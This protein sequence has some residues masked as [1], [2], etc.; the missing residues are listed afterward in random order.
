MAYL[1]KKK[2]KGKDYYYLMESKRIDGKPRHTKQIYLGSAEDVLNR[3]I[4]SSDIQ[5]PL[6]S[7]AL[8]LGGVA[9]LFDL[10]KRLEIVELIDD[11]SG[12]RSQGVSTGIYL[13]L[14]MLNRA[15]D[16]VSKMHLEEWYQNTMLSRWIP[17]Q[18]GSL[19]SQRFWDNV[20]RWD[21][22]KI[23]H[24][25]TC[26]LKKLVS[27][28]RITP[29]CLIY[30]ATNFFTYIDT[31]NEKAELAQRGHSK[32]KRNDL[33][34]VSLS[35]V[36]SKEDEIPL[37]YDV[38]R[39]NKNDSLEFSDAVQRLKKKYRDIFGQEAAVT[40]VFDRGN[41]SESN[42]RMLSDSEDKLEYVGGLKKNQCGDLYQVPKSTYVKAAAE[43][44]VGVSYYRTQMEIFGKKHT[45]V[46]T[47]NPNLENG[48]LQGI[49][50]HEEKCRRQ[51]EE[52]MEKLEKR[53]KKETKGGK[54]PTVESVTK[55]ME[56]ILHG[57]Y[58]R[59]LFQYEVTGEP[60]EIPRL[61][62]NYSEDALEKLKEEVLGKTVLF[63]SQD[64]WESEEI[65]KAYRSAW[66]LEHAF[67]QMKDS[68]YLTVRPLYCWTDS[69]I[70][71][72][73]FCCVM[74]LRLCY[75]L[76][77]ELKDKGIHTGVNQMLETLGKKKQFIHYYQQKR[78]LKEV[79]STSEKKLKTE[80][81]IQ[82]L[83]LEKYEMKS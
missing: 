82:A 36:F 44:L 28:Y 68:D 6:Y 49:R 15:L 76:K 48:Q 10:A 27:E 53:R 60:G 51:I 45:V 47:D 5:S 29:K 26:F 1:A 39:G 8:E 62:Y 71:V 25:E 74:A 69:K 11:I 65:I 66:K 57:E 17:C 13:L 18:E 79:Y 14:A 73:I 37:F 50:I 46:V 43:E 78:G 23:E 21:D 7:K 19:S 20:C 58:M 2:I 67:R 52:Q 75:I 30:D 41:N 70:K 42:I 56:K 80:E 31:E 83:S 59:T 61:R 33:K 40:L 63:T 9:A 12:K 24:F 32:E 35:L 4:H 72:H 16:P 77:K 3:L 22:A 38:Y 54:R 55:N 81:M 64:N 34:I